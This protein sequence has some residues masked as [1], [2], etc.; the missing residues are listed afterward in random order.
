M[1]SRAA[2][3][4]ATVIVSLTLSSCGGGAGDTDPDAGGASIDEGSAPSPSET[5]PDANDFCT[6]AEEIQRLDDRSQAMTNKVLGPFIVGENRSEKA[7]DRASERLQTLLSQGLPPLLDSYDRLEEGAPPEIRDDVMTMKTFTQDFVS[8]FNELDSLRD[9][10]GLEQTLVVE[11]DAQKAVEATFA[12]D[13]VT[14]QRCNV[15]L[16]D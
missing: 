8:A 16:A 3:L 13:K 5:G 12:V 10:A 14:Q 9:L 1:A 7:F 15:T 4:L 6:A 2:P 11:T